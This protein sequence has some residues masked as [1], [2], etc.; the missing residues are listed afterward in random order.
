VDVRTLVKRYL[1]QHT[2]GFWAWAVSTTVLGILALLLITKIFLSGNDLS[3][4]AIDAGQR[5]LVHIAGDTVDGNARHTRRAEAKAPDV[6]S[7]TIISKDGLA[8]A[9][10]AAI[11][12]QSDKG[13][14]P[15]VGRDGTQPWKYYAR[16]YT[17]QEKRPVVAIVFT[18]LGLSRPLT[19]DVLTL[20]HN[21]TLSFSPYAGDAKVWAQKAREE[22]F[23]SLVDLPMQPENYPLS[24]PGPY[25]LLDDLSPADSSARLH[26]VLSRF[27]GFVGVLAPENEKLT[28]NASVLR[29]T[30]VELAA[31]GVLF[32]YLK[33]PKNGGVEELAKSRSL[34][35]LAADMVIDDEISNAAIAA[36]LQ[37]LTDLAKKQGYAIGIAHSYP[38]TTETVVEW[39]QGLS[40]QGVDL[41]PVSAVATRIFP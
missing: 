6:S 17:A 11:S 13:L 22:G 24:D 21:F 7:S 31:R 26:W 36:Q 35:T 20:P 30:L 1:A 38:P 23:E 40:A 32:V 16:P 14:I 41:V 28:A 5:V 37:N 18:N 25:G 2:P 12:E 27:P 29:P 34:H 8:P 4:E 9:P 33:T 19:Q 10:L 39:A 3:K 15:I